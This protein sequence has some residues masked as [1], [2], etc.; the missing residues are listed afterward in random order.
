MPTDIYDV[1]PKEF[2]D[3][4]HGGSF[5]SGFSLY[6]TGDWYDLIL[7]EMNFHYNASQNSHIVSL[8]GYITGDKEIQ[9][10]ST[11]MSFIRILGRNVH[12]YITGV[13]YEWQDMGY[14]TIDRGE[15]S[16]PHSV[17]VRVSAQLEYR[18]MNYRR[19]TWIRPDHEATPLMDDVPIL[20]EDP[21]EIVVV[22]KTLFDWIDL[23]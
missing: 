11:G 8:N 18:D 14:S 1:S 7:D 15:V 10:V 3:L 23:E 22:Q 12:C 17:K 16:I 5:G 2:F 6:L 19:G 21:D 9:S 13:D 20:D 4:M